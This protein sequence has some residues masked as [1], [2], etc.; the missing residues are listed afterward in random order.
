[1]WLVR[2][3]FRERREHVI[4]KRFSLI[5]LFH[6]R[7]WEGHALFFSY[8]G[9]WCLINRTINNVKYL[10][11]ESMTVFCC[12][13]HFFLFIYWALCS[14]V[15]C[16]KERPNWEDKNKLRWGRKFF[17]QVLQFHYATWQYWQVKYIRIGQR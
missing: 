7:K 10:I 4:L 2:S 14:S 6:C 16:T 15:C 5:L 3:L 13:T 17:T 1:M 9:K 8:F 11:F 12:L